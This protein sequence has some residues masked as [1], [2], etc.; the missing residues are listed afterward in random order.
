MLS[1]LTIFLVSPKKLF[2][3]FAENKKELTFAA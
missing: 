1:F 2:I 3:L